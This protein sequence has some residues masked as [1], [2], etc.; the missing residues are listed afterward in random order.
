MRT[1]G[2]CSDQRSR[3]VQLVADCTEARIRLALLSGEAVRLFA[4]LVSVR[5]HMATLRRLPDL[6]KLKKSGQTKEKPAAEARDFAALLR[7]GLKCSADQSSDATPPPSGEC[8]ALHALWPPV[9]RQEKNIAVGFSL[10]YQHA[11]D[12]TRK[13]FDAGLP[14]CLVNALL[15][16][17]VQPKLLLEVS[18]R[19]VEPFE[20]PN[21]PYRENVV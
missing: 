8:F 5:R 4:Q 1:A 18:D 20:E 9:A 2:Q 15:K 6:R 7:L 16:S 12:V 17:D 3:L 21:E 13:V 14:L 11:L 10:A 19:I